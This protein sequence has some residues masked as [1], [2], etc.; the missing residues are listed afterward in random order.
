MIF[1]LLKVNY[2]QRFPIRHL[3][4]AEIGRDRRPG[5]TRMSQESEV[6]PDSQNDQAARLDSEE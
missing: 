1:K 5:F 4:R 2:K 6:T 3:A